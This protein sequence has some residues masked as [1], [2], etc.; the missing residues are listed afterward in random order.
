MM[1]SPESYKK[2]F[3]DATYEEL[4]EERDGLTRFLQEYE[5]L[6]KSGDRTGPEWNIHPQPDV[7]YQVYMDYLAELIPFMRE[8]YNKEDVWGDKSLRLMREKYNK[9]DVWGDKS[10]RLDEK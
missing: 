9:E 10:L 6:E 1:I 2:Q 7:R 8:K 3:E 5:K 4:I